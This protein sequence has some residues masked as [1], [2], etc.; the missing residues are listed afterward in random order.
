MQFLKYQR[1]PFSFSINIKL[2][3]IYELN[4]TKTTL[5]R[6]MLKM[7]TIWTKAL[8]IIK[9][10]K[11]HPPFEWLNMSENCYWS[12]VN[13][14]FSICCWLICKRCRLDMWTIVPLCLQQTSYL[15]G[16]IYITHIRGGGG[17]GL[18]CECAC[19]Y[20]TFQWPGD[21]LFLCTGKTTCGGGS[22]A[23]SIPTPLCC[24]F[25]LLP[26]SSLRWRD[27]ILPGHQISQSH[28]GAM[29]LTFWLFYLLNLEKFP[30][31]EVKTASCHSHLPLIKDWND[32]Q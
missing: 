5:F 12:C 20:S 32:V 19:A 21:A 29:L 1:P 22:T 11:L 4:L 26:I 17:G 8:Q 13:S 9:V 27:I 16:T 2:N 10:M 23:H 6:E 3:I 30:L 28:T 31:I 24:S 14:S 15:S 7:V 18:L 25:F